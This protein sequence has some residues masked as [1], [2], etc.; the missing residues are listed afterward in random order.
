MSAATYTLI[1]TGALIASV[2]AAA[3]FAATTVTFAPAVAE[4]MHAYG[5]AERATLQS[6]ILTAVSREM[7]RRPVPAG[8]AISVTVR[9]ITPTRPTR[10][11]ASADPTLDPVSTRYLGGAALSGE[12]RDASQRV[13]AT[14]S[15]SHFAPTLPLGSRSFDPWADARLS[16]DQFALKLAAACHDLARAPSAASR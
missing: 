4:K 9:D 6:A 8:L 3:P 13:V 16:I 14:V 10:E 5:E 1:A 2:L 15:Y 12:V 11:Q 7:S